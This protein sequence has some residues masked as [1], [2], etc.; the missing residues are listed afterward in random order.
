MCSSSGGREM[1]NHLA[2]L[3]LPLDH[4]TWSQDEYSD[5]YTLSY[6]LITSGNFF[7]HVSCILMICNG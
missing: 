3:S 4:L 7:F 5:K 6:R 1:S 2:E